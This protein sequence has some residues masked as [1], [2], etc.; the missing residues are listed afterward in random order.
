MNEI[1]T[2]VIKHCQALASLTRHYNDE[3]ISFTMMRGKTE[4]LFL[5]APSAELLA[6]CKNITS[7][8]MEEDAPNILTVRH[9]AEY[10]PDPDIEFHWYEYKE[11]GA[12]I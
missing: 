4:I 7:E 3:I 1:S 8:T 2:D 12:K 11:M 9:T 10:A 6:K 5:V